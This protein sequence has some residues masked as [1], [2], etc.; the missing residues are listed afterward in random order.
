ML[1][2]IQFENIVSRNFQTVEGDAEN[3]FASLCVWN[4]V[5]YC[6]G[7][8]QVFNQSLGEILGVKGMKFPCG[9][10]YDVSSVSD[11]SVML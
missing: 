5:S 11:S 6:E 9:L 3:S 7:N 10:L 4:V 1:A 8:V 2:I